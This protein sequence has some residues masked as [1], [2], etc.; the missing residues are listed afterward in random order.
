MSITDEQVLAKIEQQIGQARQAP[1]AKRREHLHAIRTLCDLALDQEAPL[2]EGSGN[3][4]R[5]TNPM[6]ANQAPVYSAPAKPVSISQEKPVK[7]EDGSNGD[8]LFDF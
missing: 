6:P 5:R 2:T 3:I 4:N 1:S 7:M 8:S